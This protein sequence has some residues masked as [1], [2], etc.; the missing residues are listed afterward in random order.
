[1]KTY[2]QQLESLPNEYREAAI[3][4]AESQNWWGQDPNS[5]CDDVYTAVCMTFDWKESAEGFDFWREATRYNFK[6]ATTKE[7][8]NTMNT[9][10][11]NNLTNEQKTA[12]GNI[13]ALA[14]TIKSKIFELENSNYKDY[15]KF[16]CDV[17]YLVNRK[18]EYI[19]EANALDIPAKNV[20]LFNEG[21]VTGLINPNRLSY[22]AYYE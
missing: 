12:L 21:V 3:S 8:T 5:K 18:S 1:M 22:V 16:A 14:Q 6:E 20:R 10:N 19:Q 2:K 4:N 17:A 7:N 13:H 11:H 9:E 15:E